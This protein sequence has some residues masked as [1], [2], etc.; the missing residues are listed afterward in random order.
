MKYCIN[1]ILPDSRPNII[2]MQDGKCSACHSHHNKKKLIGE[3][4][5]FYLKRLLVRSRK[6][7]NL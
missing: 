7:K 2:I 5:K 3:K 6:E 4:E 1:C